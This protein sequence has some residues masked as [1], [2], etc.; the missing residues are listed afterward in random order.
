AS[1]PEVCGDAALYCDPTSVPDMA[2]ALFT[3]LTDETERTRLRERGL[4]RA[5]E[6][7]WDASAEKT[8]SVLRSLL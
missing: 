3:L 4:A 8:S 2:N 1:L 5:R 6:L 7:D